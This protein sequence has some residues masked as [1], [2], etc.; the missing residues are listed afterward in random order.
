MIQV[1][2]REFK[3]ILNALRENGF[4]HDF[5]KVKNVRSIMVK[6]ASVYLVE[7]SP[8]AVNI[9]GVYIPYIGSIN[10]FRGYKKVLVDLGAVKYIANGADVMRPGIVDYDFFDEDD[11]VVVLVEKHMSP[12]AIGRA[13]LDSRLL[14]NMDRGKVLKNIHHVGDRIWKVVKNMKP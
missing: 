12:I 3:F 4:D 1:S 6:N 2:K 11:L 9:E 14:D 10:L 5:K 13:L 8:V 7:V